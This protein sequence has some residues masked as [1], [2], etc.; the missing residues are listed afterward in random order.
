MG[1]VHRWTCA[2]TCVWVCM[3]VCMCVCVICMHVCACMYACVYM[4][5][6]TH[7]YVL[8]EAGCGADIPSGTKSNIQVSA[9]QLGR[10][11]L[12][13][14]QSPGP[15]ISWFGCG[16]CKKK[17]KGIT[18]RALPR[19][20][21]VGQRWSPAGVL[22]AEIWKIWAPDTS[23]DPAPIPGWQLSSPRFPVYRSIPAA[24]FPFHLPQQAPKKWAGF[25]N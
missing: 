5:V 1:D 19:S 22:R 6:R 13:V 7:V 20:R 15:V 14:W 8:G 21:S 23:L 24:N 18:G 11:C 2:C 12:H 25:K 10:R 17:A 9:L 16:K 4:H 3:H